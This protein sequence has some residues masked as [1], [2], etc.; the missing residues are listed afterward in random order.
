MSGHPL[1]DADAYI[2]RYMVRC[3]LGYV[4][5]A[6][7]ERNRSLPM[8]RHA[9]G[10]ERINDGL[11]WRSKSGM[12]DQFGRVMPEAC[13]KCHDWQEIMTIRLE[14]ERK[15]TAD[16]ENI[17]DMKKCNKCGLVK[18][19][20]EFYRDK[21]FRDGY[22]GICK[23]CTR[24]TKRKS[25]RGTSS[26]SGKCSMSQK[27][28]LAD[29]EHRNSEL[30]TRIGGLE[31]RIELLRK[32]AVGARELASRFESARDEALASVTSAWETADILKRRL[33]SMPAP[34]PYSTNAAFDS[35]LRQMGAIHDAK[36]A[37]YASSDDPFGNFR[38]SERFGVSGFLGILTRMSDKWT[39]ICNLVRTGVARVKDESIIDTLIDLANYAVIA[40]LWLRQ[41]ETKRSDHEQAEHDYRKAA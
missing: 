16:K 31:Q 4:S 38:E 33:E 15:M 22:R 14:K 2:K 9:V 6:Q 34:E 27:P 18:K 10:P 30:L 3:A 13:E 28:K 40:T 29:L 12:S 5:S 1:L 25:E 23:E 39:R 41:D 20:T 37:D 35:V 36:R 19:L 26:T 24:E 8:L 7:C 11:G 21:S 32:E 17:P